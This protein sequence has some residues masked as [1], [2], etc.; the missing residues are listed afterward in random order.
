MSGSKSSR[1][2]QRKVTNAASARTA[3]AIKNVNVNV[4]YKRHSIPK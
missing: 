4:N 3:A 1:N 2:N